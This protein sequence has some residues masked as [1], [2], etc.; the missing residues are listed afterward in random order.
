MLDIF[1]NRVALIREWLGN[2]A[3]DIVIVAVEFN[4][5]RIQ[6]ILVDHSA[7]H[8]REQYKRGVLNGY[9]YYWLDADDHLIVGWDNAPHHPRL[10]NFP[11]HKHLGQQDQREP[12]D[13]T[14]LE[15]VLNVI[16]VTL[17]AAR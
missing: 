7:L 15:Q 14:S 4:S 1:P 5:F 12:S 8:V 13:E 6:V 3:T 10:P 9:S 11:H 17:R 2:L 16:R